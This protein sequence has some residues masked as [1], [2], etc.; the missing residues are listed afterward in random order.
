MVD[1]GMVMTDTTGRDT[2]SMRVVDPRTNIEQP[3]ANAVVV[4]SHMNKSKIFCRQHK[5]YLSSERLL[6][7]VKIK[8][9]YKLQNESCFLQR[10]ILPRK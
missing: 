3:Y 10:V 5:L 9:K 4:R 1:G 6:E 7:G 8:H 2:L